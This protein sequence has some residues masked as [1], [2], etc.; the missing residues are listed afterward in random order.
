M[1]DEFITACQNLFS[2]KTKLCD[3]ELT[4]KCAEGELDIAMSKQFK[5]HMAFCGYCKKQ[6]HKLKMNQS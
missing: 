4:Q 6:Y 1:F 3:D 2:L 5:Q